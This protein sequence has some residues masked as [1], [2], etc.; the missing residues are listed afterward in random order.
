[1]M[2]FKRLSLGTLSL[3]TL[4]RSNSSVR[5]TLP[6]KII[7]SFHAISCLQ[8]S[9][10]PEHFLPRLV[11]CEIV[12]QLRLFRA[13][14]HVSWPNPRSVWLSQSNNFKD[15]AAEKRKSAAA[16]LCAHAM[17]VAGNKDY[18]NVRLC[19]RTRPRSARSD[20][21]WERTACG[22]SSPRVP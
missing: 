20:L 13:Q 12:R 3:G 6:I 5:H 4:S 21:R 7:C 16:T 1:M 2:R 22:Q 8:T 9:A 18:V 11:C 14:R 17:T 10:A 19:S 15:H